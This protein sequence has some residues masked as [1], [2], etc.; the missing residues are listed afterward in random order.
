M[1]GSQGLR[2]SVLFQKA[3]H[4]RPMDHNIGGDVPET[5]PTLFS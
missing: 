4:L 5:E 1:Q 2:F 3:N